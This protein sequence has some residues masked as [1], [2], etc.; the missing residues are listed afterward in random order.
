MKELNNLVDVQANKIS[1]LERMVQTLQSSH[2]RVT[3]TTAFT[4]RLQSD[5][6]RDIYR[7]V[8]KEHIFYVCVCLF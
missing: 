4:L 6:L 5:E 8:V 1:H 7:V 2:H 3:P